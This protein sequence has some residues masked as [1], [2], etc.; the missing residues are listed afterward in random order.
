MHGAH[1]HLESDDGVDDDH[2]DDKEGD[3]DQGE[4]SHHDGVEHNLCN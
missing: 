2:E 1:E 3:L 4:E